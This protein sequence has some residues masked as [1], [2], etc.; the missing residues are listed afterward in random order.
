MVRLDRIKVMNL[1]NFS[2]TIF[3]CQL[4]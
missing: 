2:L 3:Y 4:Y 1:D